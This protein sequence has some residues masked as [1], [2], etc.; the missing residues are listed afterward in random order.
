MHMVISPMASARRSGGVVVYT[1]VGCITPKPDRR[2]DAMGLMTM[3]IGVGPL[4]FLALG[5][6]ANQ[7][8]ASMAS[9]ICALC[10]LVAVALSWPLCRECF[11][12]PHRA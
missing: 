3:C 7:L 4:G 12:V 2:A 5:W 11:R 8:G 6:L 1:S 9:L 10:G